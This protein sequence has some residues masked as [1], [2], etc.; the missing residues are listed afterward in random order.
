[1]TSEFEGLKTNIGLWLSKYSELL[2]ERTEELRGY[3]HML[4]Y[5][6]ALAEKHSLIETAKA[7]RDLFKFDPLCEEFS[8]PAAELDVLQKVLG[9][10][11]V[12]ELYIQTT[13]AELKLVERISQ[14]EQEVDTLLQYKVDVPILDKA[15]TRVE[16]LLSLIPID[17]RG[18]P[19]EL[20]EAK[21]R[22]MHKSNILYN[23]KQQSE[24]L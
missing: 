18:L 12:G 19:E 10:T 20:K 13:P 14:V 23:A 24:R 8:E 5:E 2:W 21:S 3:T 15:S 7:I 1:M 6:Q 22:L 16:L 11:N 9:E 17:N 4:T